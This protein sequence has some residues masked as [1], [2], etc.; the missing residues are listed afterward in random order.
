[1]SAIGV[2]SGSRTRRSCLGDG[3][4][5]CPPA[6]AFAAVRPATDVDAITATE[7]GELRPLV[8]GAPIRLRRVIPSFRVEGEFLRWLLLAGGGCCR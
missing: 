4:V 1:V 7:V 5:G 6:S 3:P 8:G 2:A